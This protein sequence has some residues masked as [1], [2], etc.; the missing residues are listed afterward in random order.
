MPRSNNKYT[1]KPTISKSISST[2]PYN[3]IQHK[4]EQPSFMSNVFQGF[5]WGTGTSIARNIFE[6][7][8]TPT[9]IAYEP[10]KILEKNECDLYKLCL[11]MDDKYECFNKM[12]QK[13]Y[14]K[15]KQI[16]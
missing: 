13:E 11:K 5:A 15:C 4:I 16:I 3:I 8:S 9:P 6:S 12:D 2:Q 10:T 1:S 7:K 14:E